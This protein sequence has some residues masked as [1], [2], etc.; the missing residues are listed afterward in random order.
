MPDAE[1]V[2]EQIQAPAPVISNE[3]HQ[4]WLASRQ[5]GIGG[6]DAA[7]VCG[8]SP[9]KSPFTLWA[10]KTALVTSEIVETDL[11]EFGK[12]F[13]PTVLGALAAATGRNVQHWPQHDVV[14][15]L[16]PDLDFIR[17]TPDAIQNDPERGRGLAQA[18]TTT[19]WLLS[20]WKDA[21]PLTV[22]VQCQHEMLVTG[23]EW[24]TAVLLPRTERVLLILFAHLE[25]RTDPSMDLVKHLVWFDLERDDKFINGTLLPAEKD[26]WMHVMAGVPPEMDGSESTFDTIKKLHPNDNG[27][28][29]ELP[30]ESLEWD[31]QLVEAKDAIKAHNEAIKKLE[32][33]SEKLKAQLEFAIGGNTFGMLPNGEV[34]SL[35]T[36]TRKS[37]TVA[38]SSYRT[39]RRVKAKG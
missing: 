6:S 3:D 14:K 18:K 31:R 21:P 2:A 7:A 33:T 11:T 35:K 10:E 39:L 27:E 4:G 24:S 22:Q 13:E 15:H 16:D 5:A 36:T 38:E 8:V 19:P 26:F 34:Y 23:A 28:M 29:F 20:D 25:A 17:C 1:Q 9:Y 12:V 37:Y 30:Q 32:L